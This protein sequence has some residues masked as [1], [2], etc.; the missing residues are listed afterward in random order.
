MGFVVEQVG[1]ARP[2]LLA[3]GLLMT[4]SG[5]AA[6]SFTL[7]WGWPAMLVAAAL[8]G[9]SASGWNGI[10]YA[11]VARLAPDGRAAEATGGAQFLAFAGLIA[12]PLLFALVAKVA[13]TLAAGYLA[14]AALTLLGSLFLLRRAADQQ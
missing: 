7:G 3:L 11:E 12:G 5:V 1:A 9:V 10:F 4:V 2:V 13:G 8:F 14:L 6:A